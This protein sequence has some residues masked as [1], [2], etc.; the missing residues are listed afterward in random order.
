[1]SYVL[2][3][4]PRTSW[5][6]DEDSHRLLGEH[7]KLTGFA[8]A[9]GV[10][11]GR[12]TSA[13]RAQ[14]LITVILDAF[15]NPF[16]PSPAHSRGVGPYFDKQGNRIE[17]RQS[18]LTVLMN[19]VPRGWSHLLLWEPTHKAGA[20]VMY[21]KGP[22]TKN[23]MDTV[24][25]GFPEYNPATEGQEGVPADG[26]DPQT[27]TLPVADSSGAGSG[28]FSTT[29]LNFYGSVWTIEAGVL[30]RDGTPFLNETSVNGLLVLTND[31]HGM[32]GTHLFY[33]RTDNSWYFFS[34]GNLGSLYSTVDDPRDAPAGNPGTFFDWQAANVTSTANSNV[35]TGISTAE[36]NTLLAGM[37]VIFIKGS[38]M[39]RGTLQSPGAPYPSVG[40][41][42]P[43]ALGTGT[44]LF[45]V[46]YV[47]QGSE[48]GNVYRWLGSSWSRM[49]D[50]SVMDRYLY[51]KVIPRSYVARIRTKLGGGSIELEDINGNPLPCRLSMTGTLVVN[52]IPLI[53]AAIN[54]LPV[55]ATGFTLPDT[56]LPGAGILYIDR[57]NFELTAVGET[58]GLWTP[59][60]CAYAGLQWMP[61]RTGGKVTSMT[62]KGNYFPN[63]H[64]MNW[65][66]GASIGQY[67]VVGGGIVPF[68]DTTYNGL[69]YG[70]AIQFGPGASGA[71]VSNV[72][73]HDFA[74]DIQSTFC[75][76]NWYSNPHV[77][78]AAP[79]MDYTGWGIAHNDCVG[80][81]CEDADVISTYAKD[82]FEGFKSR[83]PVIY[84]R[85]NGTNCIMASNNSQMRMES[86]RFIWTPNSFVAES[87][88][89]PH[90]ST[91][92]IVRAI[93]NGFGDL[94]T[95]VTDNRI[96]VQGYTY[97]GT[98]TIGGISCGDDNFTVKPRIESAIHIAPNYNPAV[99]ST[100]VDNGTSS[101]PYHSGA[102]A[103][104]AAKTEIGNIAVT[105]T[106]PHHDN[107]A[108]NWQFAA[109]RATHGSNLIPGTTRTTACDAHPGHGLDMDLW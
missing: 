40:V 64:G 36:Y 17:I 61:G 27:N 46:K 97:K 18:D 91:I 83:G 55:G 38:D 30:K 47:T 86:N 12:I 43:A 39:V 93:A 89:S 33:R 26:R 90:N 31:G 3:D 88:P 85:N 70:M 5:Y 98:A 14:S 63:D 29:T 41:S 25:A 44:G 74:S 108:G 72:W 1:M 81:G 109:I 10:S 42:S 82:A 65:Q 45:H 13:S 76:D 62:L 95:V 50:N 53:Q 67:A 58:K 77:R 71:R 20:G 87:Y 78:L 56:L 84:R 23:F 57:N 79:I 105:G 16:L 4:T 19:G 59:R 37:W 51:G 52:N 2:I 49:L 92:I 48:A 103:V 102:I 35:L 101:F 24:V 11:I 66:E 68:T 54:A 6:F 94:G 8:S 15:F 7:D 75:D 80:G 9:L 104:N 107:W 22:S 34:P 60:G 106:S 100:L 73:I 96:E 32:A 99:Q 28:T 69:Y 21:Q